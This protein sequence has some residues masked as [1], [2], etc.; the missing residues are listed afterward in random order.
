MCVS[1]YVHI[2]QYSLKI[3]NLSINVKHIGINILMKLFSHKN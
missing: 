3:I 2:K 1:M